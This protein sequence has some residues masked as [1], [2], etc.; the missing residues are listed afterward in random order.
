MIAKT[1]LCLCLLILCSCILTAIPAAC[2][3]LYIIGD[4]PVRSS[5]DRYCR[6]KEASCSGSFSVKYI[7]PALI[8]LIR[9]SLFSIGESRSSPRKAAEGFACL[10]ASTPFSSISGRSLLF[11]PANITYFPLTSSRAALYR[12][13]RSSS[14]SSRQR[15]RLSLSIRGRSS[16]CIS[17]CFPSSRRISSK[18]R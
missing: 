11:P 6:K 18:L 5:P 13:C 1:N 9:K 4:V 16:A 8:V 17:F 15:I 2:M 14:G 10:T 3:V 12:P 7:S